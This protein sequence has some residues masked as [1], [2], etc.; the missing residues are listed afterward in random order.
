MRL[1]G[2][3]ALHSGQ[4]AQCALLRRSQTGQ[5]HAKGLG[6]MKRRPAPVPPRTL[7]VSI[8]AALDK[9]ELRFGRNEDRA[10]VRIFDVRPEISED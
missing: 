4:R 5:S 8:L 1:H 3:G 6:L 2:L 9:N 10:R 7:T